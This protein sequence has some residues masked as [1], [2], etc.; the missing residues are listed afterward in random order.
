MPMSTM[1]F[2]LLQYYYI[3]LNNYL[4][5]LLLIVLHFITTVVPLFSNLIRRQKWFKYLNK[6]THK[7]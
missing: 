1:T 4:F 5:T 7:K 6:F 2:I 3:T